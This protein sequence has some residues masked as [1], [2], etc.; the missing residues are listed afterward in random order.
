MFHAM[1]FDLHNLVDRKLMVMNSELTVV[2]A[3]RYLLWNREEKL[4]RILF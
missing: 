3:R 2:L 1:N 4:G